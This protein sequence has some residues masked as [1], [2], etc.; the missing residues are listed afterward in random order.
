I[1]RMGKELDSY[2]VM[3]KKIALLAAAPDV[4]LAM[5]RIAEIIEV[6]EKELEDE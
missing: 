2:K 3:L 5:D 6:V 1:E 4:S